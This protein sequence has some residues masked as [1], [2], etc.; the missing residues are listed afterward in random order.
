M[1]LS[2]AHWPN[3]RT[4]RL[5]K[6]DIEYLDNNKIDNEGCL[7]FS[8]AYWLSLQTI[9]LCKGLIKYLG[10]NKIGQAGFAYLCK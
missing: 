7:H 3:L 5:R 10:E 9:D 2:K 8:K 1:H 4:I 6:E